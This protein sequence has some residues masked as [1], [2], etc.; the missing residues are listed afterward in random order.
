MRGGC[1]RQAFLLARHL[2]AHEGIDAQVWSLKYD[3]P[4]RQEFEAAGIPTRV[5]HWSQPRFGWVQRT[6]PV[7]RQ[8]RAARV[9]IL[10]PFTT[11]PNVVAGLAYRFSG[12]R[13]CIWGERHCGDER[14]P[15][16]ERIAVWQ[17]RRFVANSTAGIQFLTREMHV[18]SDRISFVPNGVE[19]PKLAV[20]NTWRARLGISAEQLLV[21]KVAHLTRRKDHAT[22]LRAW[23]IV[24]D[25]WCIGERPVLAL[26]GLPSD[27]FPECRRIV[28]E[29]GLQSTVRF[30]GS[31]P[32]VP[33]LL[34]ACDMAVFSSPH[35]G[36]P[37]G[38]MECMA[39]G[40]AVI[41]SD[42]PGIRD[43]MGA[44]P[45]FLYPPGDAERFACKML[46]LMRDR[47][48]RLAIGAANQ[49]RMISEFSVEQMATRHLRVIQQNLPK[50]RS[51]FRLRSKLNPAS[52][53]GPGAPE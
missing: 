31:I 34:Q 30:L 51:R 10:L 25:E 15:G 43:L 48:R 12:V 17:Y 9:D 21:V 49:T 14:V 26:A 1:E 33:D 50:S 35:E 8:L 32:D 16:M 24:Q 36:M 41:A 2:R 45:E 47:D 22:L 39:H 27:T 28:Q 38:V 4:Y 7:V 3:S 6:L 13:L 18:E 44:T 53:T 11:W 5:L 20:N 52:Q 46:E 29:H 42:L 19:E 40:K 37:N 23:K